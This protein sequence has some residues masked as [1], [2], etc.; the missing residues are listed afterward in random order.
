[1][2]VAS[3]A[4]RALDWRRVSDVTPTLTIDR[5]RQ[6]AKWDAVFGRQVF[7]P[8]ARQD[9]AAGI[10]HDVLSQNRCH[11]AIPNRERHVPRVRVQVKVSVFCAGANV[12]G[13]A[14]LQAIRDG[15]MLPYPREDVRA[16]A[17]H[18]DIEGA[19]PS[20]VQ[21][22]SKKAACAHALYLGIEPTRVGRKEYSA[23]R[24]QDSAT[25]GAERASDQ[26][27]FQRPTAKTVCPSAA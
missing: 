21:V 22:A 14:D 23:P 25:R 18:P 15:A 10:L 26:R 4:H 17:V 20:M 27:T 19:V 1:M 3:P 2:L 13:M 7:S 11:S 16:D 8:F 12:T 5:A 24:R 6:R 9:A